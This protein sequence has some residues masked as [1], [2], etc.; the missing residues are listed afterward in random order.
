MPPFATCSR[1]QICPSCLQPWGGWAGC[2]SWRWRHWGP[3]TCCRRVTCCPPGHLK[4]P[5]PTSAPNSWR[6]TAVHS[7]SCG[8][9]SCFPKKWFSHW[10][11]PLTLSYLW[12]FLSPLLFLLIR[13]F[14]CTLTSIPQTQALLNK[15]RLPL[16][17][18]LHP[19]RDLQV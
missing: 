15:A 5:N 16:G 2:Q 9:Y 13:S 19:F 7:K 14:R 8:M 3:S 1:F 4:P 17:L 6:S 18:L 10:S 12:I 11:S